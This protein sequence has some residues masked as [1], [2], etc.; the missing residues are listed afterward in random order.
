MVVA[1]DVAEEGE[2]G[3]EGAGS[4]VVTDA[5]CLRFVVFSE[6]TSLSLLLHCVFTLSS[7]LSTLSLVGSLIRGEFVMFWYRLLMKEILF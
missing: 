1:V 5:F 4:E 3:G 6:S 2:G 7:Y